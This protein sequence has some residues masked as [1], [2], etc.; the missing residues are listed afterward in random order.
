MPRCF[1]TS[2]HVDPWRRSNPR[3][4][5][6]NGCLLHDMHAAV[7]VRRTWWLCA[8]TYRFQE[9]SFP[10]TLIHRCMRELPKLS[11][12]GLVK[13]TNE[14]TARF[15]RGICPRRCLE[16]KF[17]VGDAVVCRRLADL[18]SLVALALTTIGWETYPTQA[19][20]PLI[21]V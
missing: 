11:T 14:H 17:A 9:S 13:G 16:V 19:C 6:L 3:I 4:A 15:P 10:S 5:F 20:L 21:E 7:D 12:A 18:P 8:C 1:P 2:I